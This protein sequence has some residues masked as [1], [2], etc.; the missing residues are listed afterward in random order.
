MTTR[1]T[2]HER[3]VLITNWVFC[4]WVFFL[5]DICTKHDLCLEGQDFSLLHIN[6][7]GIKAGYSNHREFA[8]LTLTACYDREI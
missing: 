3:D 4:L 8:S 2:S 5:L 7:A 1:L 6:Q